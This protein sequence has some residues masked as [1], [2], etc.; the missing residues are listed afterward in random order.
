MFASDVFKSKDTL[1][2]F[3]GYLSIITKRAESSVGCKARSGMK[4]TG[5]L[6]F[7]AP[8]EN[9]RERE[10]GLEKRNS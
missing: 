4:P 8:W 9:E 5:K 3:F 2:D 1:T 10:R 7:Y 6:H